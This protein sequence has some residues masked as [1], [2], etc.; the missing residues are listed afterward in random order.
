MSESL[1]ILLSWC[2]APFLYNDRG[3]PIAVSRAEAASPVRNPKSR[4][5]AAVVVLARD[6]D[7]EG[8]LL[9]MGRLEKRFNA[10]FKY[11]YVFLNNEAFGQ[12]FINRWAAST[13]MSLRALKLG[14]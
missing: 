1:D 9:S 10:Q 13:I 12:S 11:P 4:A 14:Q 3:Q 8:V 5:R 2:R 7:C 6:S